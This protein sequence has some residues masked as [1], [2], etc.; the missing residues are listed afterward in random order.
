M[1][2]NLLLHLNCMPDICKSLELWIILYNRNDTIHR[3]YR[4]QSLLSGHMVSDRYNKAYFDLSITA[5]IKHVLNP[6]PPSLHIRKVE[7]QI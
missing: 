3:S 7:M 5:G 4:R 1:N 2:I 6:L